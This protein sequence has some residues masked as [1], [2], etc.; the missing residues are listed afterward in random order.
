MIW[1]DWFSTR[2][3]HVHQG[4]WSIVVSDPAPFPLHINQISTLPLPHLLVKIT[5]QVTIPSRTFVIVP[6]TFT[7]TP[8]P[9][10]Y[11]NFTGTPPTSEQNLF[12]VPLLKIFGIKL[13][14][15]LLCTIINTIPC[16]VILPNNWHI[17][18]IKPLS[19]ADNSAQPPSI[20]EVTHGLNP[21]TIGINHDQ[22][23][24]G[25]TWMDT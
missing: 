12:I 6:T 21:D 15:H 5:T 23:N 20:N 7:N 1:I 19:Y 25:H 18:E 8:T 10:C 16:N 11:Y 2:Q 13:P 14:V 3:L 22:F 17:V 24:K 9:N 4:P